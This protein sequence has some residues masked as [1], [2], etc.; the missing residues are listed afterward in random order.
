MTSLA[1]KL[2]KFDVGWEGNEV[3]ESSLYAL[4]NTGSWGAMMWD[5]GSK[6]GHWVLV[7]GVDDA[8]NVIIYDPYQGSRYLM[9]EQEF[10]EVWNGHSVY[11][12]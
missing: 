2:N 9:T 3:S 8:G 10:K 7:K 5:S 11:K 12:P 4:S 1:N 6:V